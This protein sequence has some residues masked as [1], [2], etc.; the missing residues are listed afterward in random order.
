M[1]AQKGQIL[2]KGEESLRNRFPSPVCLCS[3]PF[4]P[5][6]CLFFIVDKEGS[7]TSGWCRPCFSGGGVMC[8]SARG[9]GFGSVDG[10]G[11]RQA[12]RRLFT[13]C[14]GD[15]RLFFSDLGWLARVLAVV[16][17]LSR[18]PNRYRAGFR[19]SR[20]KQVQSRLVV[21]C[22][23]AGGGGLDP[24]SFLLLGRGQEGGGSG[25]LRLGSVREGS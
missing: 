3:S 12:D 8:D 6:S 14:W 11:S 13:M 21:R 10:G 18:R 9:V 1:V 23:G 7:R 16:V 25:C 22:A 24:R 4:L 19:L 15:L 5:L 17:V 2:S 20:L